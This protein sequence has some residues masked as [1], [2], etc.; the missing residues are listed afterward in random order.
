M[1][2]IRTQIRNQM[3]SELLAATLTT[4]GARIETTRLRP[5][6]DSQMP[7]AI[8]RNG[9]EANSPVMKGPSGRSL[10]RECNFQVNVHAAANTGLDELL[11]TCCVEVES[12]LGPS[13]LNGLVKS[14]TLIGT[15]FAYNEETDQTQG[16][17]LMTWKAIYVTSEADPSQQ[18]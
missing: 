15:D 13:V 8:I 12:V 17:A 16:I 7:A 5:I 4:L 14:L 3:K 1:T 6:D 18:L 9:P 2:H 11:D 10:R